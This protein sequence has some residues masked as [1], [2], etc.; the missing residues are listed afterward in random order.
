MACSVPDRSGV[1][2]LPPARDPTRRPIT[3]VNRTRSSAINFKAYF[4]EFIGTFAL[5]FV[6]VGSIAADHITGGG[7]GI[8]GIALAFGLTIAVMATAT[9]P[10]SGGHFNPAVTLGFFITRK[11]DLTNTIGY[12]AAQCFGAIVGAVSLK[13]CISGAALEAVKLGTPVLADGVTVGMGLI[14]EVVLTFLLVFVIFGTAVDSRAP[15]VGALYVG[16]AVTAN[17]FIGGPLTGAAM[18]PARYLGPALVSGQ[19]SEAW[20]YWVGPV[21]GGALA[22][23][24]CHHTLKQK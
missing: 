10:I 24:V 9:G 6:G 21:A 15:K 4:A 23:L 17:V 7:V 8:V 19:L 16:L 1:D 20:L 5:I 18:N 3:T 13:S 14:L 22:A 12:I 11:I 2:S